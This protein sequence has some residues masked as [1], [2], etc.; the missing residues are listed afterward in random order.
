MQLP[1]GGQVNNGGAWFARRDGLHDAV[2]ESNT[3]DTEN[4][5][6]N[7]RQ[8]PL[9]QRLRRREEDSE[10]FD[11]A[12]EANDAAGDVIPHPSYAALLEF[13]NDGK[14]DRTDSLWSV[15]PER[16]DFDSFDSSELQPGRDAFAPDFQTANAD[17][18]IG[19]TAAAEVKMGMAK[20][21]L[22]VSTAAVKSKRQIAQ[23][24]LSDVAA[25]VENVAK[26]YKT[27]CQQSRK[28]LRFYCFKTNLAAKPANIATAC[29]SWAKNGRACIPCKKTPPK[30]KGKKTFA[31]FYDLYTKIPVT[32]MY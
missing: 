14:L 1:S 28:G 30:T 2:S 19:S 23:E 18:V 27:L 10:Y 16:F 21:T 15:E 11:P 6:P 25:G 13:L 3:T 5:A 17:F 7:A 9:W 4:T 20:A 8:P 26:N 29:K 22:S 32:C 24:V 31:F 12:I